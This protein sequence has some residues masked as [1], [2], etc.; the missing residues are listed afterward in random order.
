MVSPGNPLKRRAD[1]A[2]FAERLASAATIADRRW[3]VATGIE[4]ALG[5][6]RTADTLAQLRRRF[7]RAQFVW[8]MGADNL[9]QLPRWHRWQDICAAVPIAVLPR[10]GETRGALA[11][12]AAHVLRHARIA[13]RRAASLAG[14]PPPAWTWLPV[15]ENPLSA[16]ALRARAC[17]ARAPRG[18]QGDRP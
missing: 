15:R 10:P 16:T 5:T 8:I 1:M 3:L 18:I 12:Q 6:R 4:S 13:A 17:K 9:A 14:S 11:G 7:P 2:P